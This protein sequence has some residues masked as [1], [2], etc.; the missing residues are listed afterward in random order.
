MQELEGKGGAEAQQWSDRNVAK[1]AP[2][3]NSCPGARCEME[4]SHPTGVSL[5]SAVLLG[6]EMTVN[7]SLGPGPCTVYPNFGRSGRI[8]HAPGRGVC[9]SAWPPPPQRLRTQGF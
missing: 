4:A 2:V 7:Y 6:S 5:H 1:L 8:A 9:N 3:S